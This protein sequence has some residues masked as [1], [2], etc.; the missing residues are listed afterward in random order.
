MEEI[1]EEALG[2]VG[3]ASM[4]V[5]DEEDG[6]ADGEEGLELPAFKKQLA[7]LTLRNTMCDSYTFPSNFRALLSLAQCT[8]RLSRSCAT[9]PIT[10]DFLVQ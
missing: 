5:V 10:L 1:T 4:D 2:D 3:C 6:V 9:K 8:V 7:A